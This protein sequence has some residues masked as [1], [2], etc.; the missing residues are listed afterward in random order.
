M[1]K[2]MSMVIIVGDSKISKKTKEKNLKKNEKDEQ[3]TTT[4]SE[5]YSSKPSNLSVKS[6]TRR[7]TN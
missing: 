4:T 1:L 2:E 3:H 5:E 7:P 6:D